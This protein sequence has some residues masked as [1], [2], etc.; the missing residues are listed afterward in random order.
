MGVA[1][2]GVPVVVGLVGV[3]EVVAP[4]DDN[5]DDDEAPD[6]DVE[7][8]ARSDVVINTNIPRR[9]CTSAHYA[10]KHERNP[11]SA[12]TDPRQPHRVGA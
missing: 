9:Q 1:V 10:R 7:H 3:A 5:V 12:G 8:A 2:A 4:D 6:D 11:D